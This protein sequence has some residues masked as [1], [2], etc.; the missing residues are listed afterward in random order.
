[1]KH[2]CFFKWEPGTTT[3]QQTALF[4]AWMTLPAIM[5]HCVAVSCGEAIRWEHGEK[6]GFHAG[7]VVDLALSSGDGVAEIDT[8]ATSDAYQKINAEFLA[9]IRKDYVVMDYAEHGDHVLQSSSKL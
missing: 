9:P 7:L 4:Q 1:M 2:L 6:N 8:Y 5:P 3:E